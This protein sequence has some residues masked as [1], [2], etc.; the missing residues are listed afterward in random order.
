[1]F[2]ELLFGSWSKL[3]FASVAI[4]HYALI[5]ALVGSLVSLFIQWRFFVWVMAA[6]RVDGPAKRGSDAREGTLQSLIGIDEAKSAVVEIIDFL[7]NP[8]RYRAMGA[9]I[10]RG[11]LLVGA[12]GT[13]KTSLAR[14]MAR[15]ADVP[16]I[17]TDAASLD[18]VFFGIGALRI[19]SLFKQARKLAKRSR[20]N[21]A[22]VFFDEIDALGNRARGFSSV[23]GGS[24]GNTTLNRLLIEMDGIDTTSNVI[25]VAAT[26]F[27]ELL[28]PA[29][30]RPGRFDRKIH[31]PVPNLT[32]RKRLFAH[33]LGRIKARPNIALER[34]TEMTVNFS[35]ADIKAAVNEASLLAVR[36][37]ATDV[38]QEHLE[39]AVDL[40]SQQSADRRS[41]GGSMTHARAGDLTVRLGDVIG[42]EE[43]KREVAQAVRLLRHAAKIHDTGARM[44]RGLLLLGPPGTGKTLL[45]KAM[46]NEA[47]VP[48]YSLSGADFVELFVGMG[49][50]RVREVY[51][52]ARKHKAAIVFIDELDALGAR[53]TADSGGLGGGDREYNQTINQL[54]VELDGFGR[55][56]VLTVAA[57]NFEENLDP[58]LLR[59]GR[60]DRRV[61]VPLPDAEA[62]R[63]LFRHYLN[64]VKHE[65]DLDL[66][67]IVQ[68]SVNFSG[69]DIA[70][71]VNAAA[72]NVIDSDRDTVALEDLEAAMKNER[73]ALTGRQVGS[74]GV[75]SRISDP[76]VRVEH[77]VGVDEAKREVAEV[78]EL[79]RAPER[80]VA[81]G[82][83]APKGILFAGP[84]GTGKTMLAQA[85][86]NEAGVPFYAL[87][88]SDFQ[89]MWRG[90]P[91]RR[92]RAVYRQA[93]RHPAAIIFID[94][95][96]AIGA[97]RS[98]APTAQQDDNVSLDALLVELD[99]FG[100]SGVLTIGATN[101]PDHLDAALR[102][103]G[104]FDRII[105][106]T[107]PDLEARRHVLR[108]HASGVATSGDIDLDAIARASVGCSAADLM[109]VVK[110]AGMLALRAGRT[111]IVQADLNAGFERV[112]L[113]GDR[114][115]AMS[116][117]ER[118]VTAYHES[119][120]AIATVLLDPAREVRKVSIVG[121]TNGALGY[122]W[123]IPKEERHLRSEREILT[124]I[125]IA[126]AGAAAE[127]VAFGTMTDGASADLRTV[128]QIVKQMV[129]ELG[130]GGVMYRSEPMSESL[131]EHLDNAMRRITDDCFNEVLQLL[132][133]KRSMLDQLAGALLARET[134]S[135]EELHE[136]LA[137]P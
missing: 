104:R 72:L 132:A 102:R 54:L 76:T 48:F 10:P 74:S 116:D 107:L 122:T 94:E 80:A 9:E 47:G 25:V 30:L 108:H 125:K 66:G 1:M 24:T 58:A 51:G 79:L 35:G 44:P 52:Q 82:I 115:L 87:A 50:H 65:P 16:F 106:F 89:S 57:S 31:V 117:V 29:L 113:G 20:H 98:F 77:V 8:D 69:A 130:M 126:L 68:A 96:E 19:R 41:V 93:R 3:F 88:G 18:E 13:G 62:R 95:L 120:H 111:S 118:R 53:S 84:P 81:V 85:M 21:A 128:G 46:A 75:S 32:A 6:R 121:T 12:P 136:V 103:P 49:A 23:T 63:E 105:T 45:A 17:G 92:I 36:L 22:I 7:K 11:V 28:D 27:E 33:Y 56:S 114:R 67:P 131:R 60:F 91:A 119:G 78:I 59:P 99:G 133:T 40:I 5:F 137:A 39:Q 2:L 42:A 86:A 123:G 14:A 70:H 55:S 112:V 4:A 15:E 109:N 61:Y 64:R 34:L 71:V 83:T 90:E 127:K 38:T 135:A 100:S 110:E 26:N 129:C 97:A 134:L 124:S 37:R 43:A 101:H 73:A